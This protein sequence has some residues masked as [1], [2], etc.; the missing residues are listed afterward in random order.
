MTEFLTAKQ[1]Q[2]ERQISE[3]SFYRLIRLGVLP[4]GERVGLRGRRWR[5]DVIE[6]AFAALN[7]RDAA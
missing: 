2:T 5:R 7:S 4:Q 6:R 3:P 1:I